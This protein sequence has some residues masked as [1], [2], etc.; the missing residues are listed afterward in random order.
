MEG[1]A[2][3]AHIAWTGHPGLRRGQARPDGIFGHRRFLFRVTESV[4]V[5]EIAAADIRRARRLQF[6]EHAVVQR[7]QGFRLAVGIAD[8]HA[9]VGEAEKARDI[10]PT[11]SFRRIAVRCYRAQLVIDENERGLFQFAGG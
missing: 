2:D 7:R 6:Q 10:G 9:I 1:G 8:L 5:G 3:I 4:P 11:G